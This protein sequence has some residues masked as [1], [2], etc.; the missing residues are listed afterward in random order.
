MKYV[1]NTHFAP[2]TVHGR[3]GRGVIVFTKRFMPEKADKWTGQ[4][5]STGYTELTDDELKTLE[6]TSRTFAVYTGRTGKKALLAVCDDLPPEAKTPHEALIDARK[7]ARKS[8]AR[9]AELDAEIVTLKAALLDAENKYKQLQAASGDE[10][11]VKLLR[12]ENAKLK[13]DLEK[14][15]KKGGKEKDFA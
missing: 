15:A 4:V 11:A 1:Q 3:D 8:A 12:D 5:T 6:E 7:E 2:I 9:I 14:A 10:G 13:A